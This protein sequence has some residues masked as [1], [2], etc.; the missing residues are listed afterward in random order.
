M[1]PSDMH[2]L[3]REV[4]LFKE[5][6]RATRLQLETLNSTISSLTLKIDECD[7]KVC[8]LDARVGSIEARLVEGA[9]TSS[10]SSLLETIEQ[11]KGEIN[12]RD[13][14]LLSNDIEITC[15]PEEK[16]ENLVQIVNILS[17]KLGVKLAEQDLVS[18]TRVGRSNQSLEAYPPPRP[19]PIAVRLARRVSRDQLM[20]AARVRRG[21][22]T[23]DTGLPAPHRRF[24]VN[25]RLTRSNRQLFRQARDIGTRLGWRFIWTRDGKIFARKRQGTDCPRHRIQTEGDLRRVFGSDAV[26]SSSDQY[27]Q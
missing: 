25:E 1:E 3:L 9:T 18:A 24:Y 10:S 7:R 15:I 14:D 11:L 8:Q 23:E 6:M 20:L 21:I 26:G 13:Q 2:L 12:D 17:I 4:R 16:G 5:E 22:T 27:S 19:R